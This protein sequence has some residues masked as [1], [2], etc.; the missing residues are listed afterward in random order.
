MPVN[1]AVRVH[2]I[3]PP[4][5]GDE[6][7]QRFWGYHASTGGVELLQHGYGL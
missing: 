3:R 1:A 4:L 6:G 7:R 5:L 2:D